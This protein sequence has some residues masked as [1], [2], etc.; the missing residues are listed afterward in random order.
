VSS[1]SPCGVYG[2]PPDAGVDVPG[3]RSPPDLAGLASLEAGLESP[4]GP[5]VNAGPRFGC[6]CVTPERSEEGRGDC[7]AVRGDPGIDR[8]DWLSFALCTEESIDAGGASCG[9]D[10]CGVIIAGSLM[11][12]L[13]SVLALSSRD[14]VPA[15][16][17]GGECMA[18]AGDDGMEERCAECAEAVREAGVGE[19]ALYALASC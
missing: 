2:R 7:G 13:C 18:E 17:K 15:G 12:F 19:G 10:T 8:D 3:V 5:N 1:L 14:D 11:R 4:A 6:G 16:V 9:G